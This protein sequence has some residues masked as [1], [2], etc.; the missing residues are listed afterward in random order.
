MELKGIIEKGENRSLTCCSS[1]EDLII[2]DVSL[3]DWLEQL[4]KQDPEEHFN[5]N[6]ATPE[7]AVKY[8]ILDTPD[9]ENRSF[10]DLSAEVIHNMIYA[11]YEGG[12]YSEYT[13]GYGGFDYVLGKPGEGHSVFD[14]LKE[15]LG[16]YV[17]FQI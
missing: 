3:F 2:G 12:C 6:G 14:E 17:H 13:C 10:N 15:H 11:D 1:I 5:G 16:K 7:Y 8:V 4:F 9:L